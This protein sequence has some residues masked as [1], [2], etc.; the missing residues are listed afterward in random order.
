V[1]EWQRG[2]VRRIQ[3]RQLLD[4]HPRLVRREIQ[5][6]PVACPGRDTD[7]RDA[8]LLRESA[9]L[10]APARSRRGE[11]TGWQGF[12]RQRVS[13]RSAGLSGSVPMSGVE[14]RHRLVMTRG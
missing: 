2:V 4:Q 12:P 6:W 11:K 7:R 5:L 13:R 3:V 9:G 8:D 14:C 10:A 1:P